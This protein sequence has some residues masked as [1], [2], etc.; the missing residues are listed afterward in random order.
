MG[1]VSDMLTKPFAHSTRPDRAARRRF[2]SL[3]LLLLLAAS[4]VGSEVDPPG[5]P[6]A[7]PVSPEATAYSRA[8]ALYQDGRVAEAAKLLEDAIDRGGSG[9]G[10][11]TLLG[12]CRLRT[13]QIVAARA[14]F[15]LALEAEPVSA[16]AT[17][18]LGYVSLRQGKA[19]EA[20]GFFL[21]AVAADPSHA[22]G[23]KGLGLARQAQGNPKGA[24]EALLK[25]ASLAPS[26][27]ETRELLE[28]AGGATA[29]LEERRL[30]EAAPANSPPMLVSH[31]GPA[32]FE[33][34]ANGKWV[35]FFVK[36]VNLGTALPG[37]FPAEFPDDP[38]LYRRWFDLMGEMGLNAVRLYT[39][40][41]PSLYRALEEHNVAHPDQKLW[42]VQGV[43]TELPVNDD[44]DDPRFME[45]FSAEIR[46]V[47]DAVHGNIEIPPRPGHASGRYETDLSGDLL[48]WLLGR[49]WEPFSV[50]AYDRKKEGRS[51]FDGEYVTA[52]ESLPFE[53][54][55][56]SICDRA[57]A[58]ETE[59]Y[60]WQHPVGYVSWPT[61]DPLVHPTESTAKEETDIRRRMGET[62][63]EPLLEYD[64]DAVN[65]DS[66][67]IHATPR[68]AAGFYA[69]YHVYPYYPDFMLLEPGYA[70]ARDAEGV[71]RYLGY[72]QALEKH[73]GDQPV[74]IAEFGV[75]S[76]R[77]IAHFHPE[78]QNHGGHNTVEQGRIDARLFRDV[79]DAGMAG[80]ILFSWMDEWFKRNWLVAIYESPPERNPLWL[81]ALDP[82]QNYGLLGAWPGS[83]GWKITLDGKGDDWK[84]AAVL[85]AAGGSGAEA[86]AGLLR[87]LRV[88]QDE[89]Y[90]Y[91]RLDLDPASS[92]T[93][94]DRY[95]Y[96]IGVDTYD[97]RLGDHR[98]PT[99]VSMRTPIGMEFLI[100]LGGEKESR[101]LVDRP[102][103]LFTRRLK[104]PYRSIDNEAGDFIEICVDTNRGRYGR[105]GT[106]YPGRG[107]CRSPLRRGSTDP[108]S[109]SYDSLA[110]WIES[111]TG[112]FI[113]MRIAWGL[114]NVTDPSS[115][116]VVHETS[117]REGVVETRATEGFRFHVL[118][119]RRDGEKLSV[120][121][122]LPRGEKPS[123]DAYPLFSW[124]GWEQP[125]YHLTLKE[126]YG[127]VR[128]AL[129]TIPTSPEGK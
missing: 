24:H 120:V 74:L 128:E 4:T 76:S 11:Y 71:S 118:A 124:P 22:E 109:P 34:L 29:I 19:A 17:A 68:L 23:W 55:L 72:L 90:L 96:W 103:D 111:P 26:D 97:E 2:T 40:H 61:L 52:R 106:F 87:G 78:G 67:H 13:S 69:S 105:N 110:D 98:F 27:P 58:H 7:A 62:L 82:E 86:G 18:G 47:I 121:D 1:P 65:I 60:G 64:N 37:K 94:W 89:A 41:P 30:R 100:Q 75:P 3:A 14:S 6:Q 53:A 46:R 114:L 102:Y 83:P 70:K 33:V 119:L 56:A 80:G 125:S 54:W 42:L 44:Y 49:E 57:A 39:L 112:D 117:R 126:G 15:L 95:R 31:T 107:Y 5:K 88:T 115:R 91:V 123:M 59:R 16:D 108:A 51:R 32:R 77:G 73:H 129:K 36:G 9:A 43:W 45:E 20:E 127:I 10:L 35:P 85:Y 38:V 12:W 104:R 101:I 8:L 93:S 99:P 66:K 25:A 84:D 28:R 21:K 116:Q 48:L 81:N 63:P 92:P 113:E 50:E 79:H 122:Q